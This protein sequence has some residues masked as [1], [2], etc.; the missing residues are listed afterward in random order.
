MIRAVVT[1]T[2]MV[3]GHNNYNFNDNGQDSYNDTNN[4]NANYKDNYYGHDH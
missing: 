2:I 1:I 3:N 4:G